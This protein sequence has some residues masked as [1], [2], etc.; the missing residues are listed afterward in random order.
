MEEVQCKQAYE[1]FCTILDRFRQAEEFEP[2]FDPI[3][4]MGIVAL[5]QQCF[6]AGTTMMRAYLIAHGCNGVIMFSPETILKTAHAVGMIQDDLVWQDALRSRG[7]MERIHEDTVADR[8][9]RQA[10]AQY[11]TLFETLK[12]EIKERWQ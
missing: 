10:K 4:R 12:Q 11:I 2:P 6:D 9:A 1:M 8:I 3:I 7:E 5:F